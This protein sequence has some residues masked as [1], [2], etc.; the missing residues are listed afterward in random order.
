MMQI[1]CTVE[2]DQMDNSF[3]QYL[4]IYHNKNRL[5][6]SKSGHTGMPT[7]KIV[8]ALFSMVKGSNIVML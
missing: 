6:T 4:A 5:N 3:A 8:N 7:S 2:C 1:V